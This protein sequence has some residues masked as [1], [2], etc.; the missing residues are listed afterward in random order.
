MTT[1]AEILDSSP[2]VVSPDMRVQ[3]LAAQLLDRRAEGACV[4]S[5]GRLVGVVTA[6]DLVFKEKNLHLPTFF[7]FMEAVI[8][9]GMHR[10]EEEVEKMAGLT[11]GEIM[12]DKPIVVG[13]GDNLHTIATLMVEKQL[14]MVPVVEDGVLL[15]VVDKRAVLVAAFPGAAG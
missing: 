2:L 9:L 11:V 8:P 7:T 15:G 4:V 6:M 12:T 14:S 5:N 10:A 1:A 13:P 3:Q